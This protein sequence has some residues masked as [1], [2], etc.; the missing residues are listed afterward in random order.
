MPDDAGNP[1]MASA[2]RDRPVEGHFATMEQQAHA[3]RLG[4]WLF[5]SSEMLLFAGFFALF[6]AYRAHFPEGFAEGVRHN[7]KVLGSINTGVLLF[8]SYLVAV[9][10][11]RVR[12]G[13][14][15]LAA[16]HVVATIALGGAFLAIKV[17]EYLHHFHEGIYPGG[18]GQFFI[19]HTTAGL[20]VFWTLYFL[21]TGLHA[22]HVT[23]GM[24]LLATTLLGMRQGMITPHAP[25]RMEIAAVY[26][27][28]IDVIWI[29]LWPLLYLAP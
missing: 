9:A 8:S 15:G 13:R 24:G 1:I 10:V 6:M 22:L 21:A 28:L 17:T 3:A 7:T 4:M 18:H 20:P 14:L 29:F 27:H 12:E 16:V 23:I 11:H 19:D 2:P 26:W 5:L 25:Q